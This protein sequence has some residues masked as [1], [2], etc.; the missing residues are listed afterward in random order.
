MLTKEHR[1]QHLALWGAVCRSPR[2]FM[3]V[4]HG[5]TTD[6]QVSAPSCA[7]SPRVLP[8]LPLKH[9][10]GC[11]ALVPLNACE[12]ADPAHC[13]VNFSLGRQN[14]RSSVRCRAAGDWFTREQVRLQTFLCRCPRAGGRS[15]GIAAALGAGRELRGVC[16]RCPSPGGQGK[17]DEGSALGQG[18][19]R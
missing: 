7:R 16:S 18:E 1:Q 15:E 6:H 8:E 13:L 12:N 3:S 10:T 11:C 9:K 14:E 19:E 5:V 4:V 17:G 2:G